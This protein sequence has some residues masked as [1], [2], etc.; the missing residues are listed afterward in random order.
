MFVADPAASHWDVVVLG[1][2]FCAFDYDYFS[3]HL[4]P[5]YVLSQAL[6]NSRPS[7]VKTLH[8]CGNVTAASGLL[9]VEKVID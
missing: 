6:V 8:G 1:E 9:D 3:E 5:V 4:Q 7:A 2:D